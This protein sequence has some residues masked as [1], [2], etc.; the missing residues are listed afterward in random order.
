MDLGF[1]HWHIPINLLDTEQLAFTTN[2]S[3]L[4]WAVLS[5]GIKVGQ[6]IFDRTLRRILTKYKI[7][8]AFYY[9]DDII[10]FFFFRRTY[11]K[12]NPNFSILESIKLKFS[13]CHFDQNKINFLGH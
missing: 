9:F 4:E 7:D 3:L 12:P 5:Y 11:S 10:I 6:S 2:S 1:G 8:F 13:K